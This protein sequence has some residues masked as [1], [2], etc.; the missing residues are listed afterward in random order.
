[1]EG[2]VGVVQAPTH[3]CFTSDAAEDVSEVD[4][5]SSL[6]RTLLTKA[7]EVGFN[8]FTPFLFLPPFLP[9][10]I[11]TLTSSIA[12]RTL[13]SCLALSI[14]PVRDPLCLGLENSR[15]E[16]S[17]ALPSPTIPMRAIDLLPRVVHTPVG[18]AGSIPPPSVFIDH[19]TQVTVMRNHEPVRAREV[20]TSLTRRHHVKAVL[21]RKTMR[22]MPL[23]FLVTYNSVRENTTSYA[24]SCIRG[25]PVERL[26]KADKKDLIRRATHRKKVALGKEGSR[27][28]EFTGIP[29]LPRHRLHPGDL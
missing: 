4:G 15:K 7:E 3:A 11:G 2:I 23:K 13:G 5:S 25:R 29:R 14:P 16:R 18:T 24:L 19:T 22:K 28:Q 26:C 27:G 10:L 8:F 1:M 20:E 6:T 12:V 21:T 9:S 17:E